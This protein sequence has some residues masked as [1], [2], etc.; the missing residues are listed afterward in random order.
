MREVVSVA[1]DH[2]V[3]ASSTSD[4]S[5]EPRMVGVAGPSGVGK[6]TVASMV[7]A[8]E[9]VRAS[10]WKGVLWLQAGQG[11]E[12]RLPDLMLRLADMVYKTV[13]LEQCSPPREAGLDDEPEDGAAYI[14]EVLSESR[15]HL[16]VVADDVS[17]MEVLEELKR[18]GW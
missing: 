9:D 17:D 14:Q 4:S 3:I 15:R 2:L 8:R 5:Q 16:L 1:S 13:M 18:V 11:A 6:S 10:F 7:L 12:A